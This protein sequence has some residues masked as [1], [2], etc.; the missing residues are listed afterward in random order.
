MSNCLDNLSSAAW[1]SVPRTEL[2]KPFF[3][4]LIRYAHSFHNTWFF[5]HIIFQ[6]KFSQIILISETICLVITYSIQ[7]LTTDIQ[8]WSFSMMH[9][10][11]W[12]KKALC[13]HFSLSACLLNNITSHKRKQYVNITKA[14]IKST[15]QYK[16][17]VQSHARTF[18]HPYSLLDQ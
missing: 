18:L 12:R 17:R 1:I 5:F 13:L 7:M 4:E 6:N 16:T 2:G 10:L 3:Q 14:Q 15:V 8:F 11:L 9:S